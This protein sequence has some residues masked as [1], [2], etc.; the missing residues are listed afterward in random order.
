MLNHRQEFILGGGFVSLLLGATLLN[1]E[2]VKTK[3]LS[4]T[5]QDLLFDC[6]L[7]DKAVN[8]HLLVLTDTVS[9]VHGLQI[10]LRV[11][12]AVEQNDNVCRREID[13]QTTCTGSEKEEKFL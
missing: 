13:T 5:F 6:V 9:A 1:D 10:G 12:I 4:G 11:P 2:L 7:S 3:F 8:V